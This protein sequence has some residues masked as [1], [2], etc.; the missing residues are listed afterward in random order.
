MRALRSLP[1]APLLTVALALATV[2]CREENQR[3]GASHAALGGEIA[4]RVGEFD[5]PVSLVSGVARQRGVAPSTALALLIEDALAASRALEH[6]LDQAADVR[7]ATTAAKARATL[8]RIRETARRTPPTDEEVTEISAIHWTEVDRPETF[9]VVHAVVR[10]P[11]TPDAKQEAAARGVAAAIA[12]AEVGAEDASTFEARA[13]AIPHGEA[14]VVVQPLE[15]F[16]ADGRVATPGHNGGYDPR[17]TSGAATLTRP[18]STSDVVE[19][20]FGWHVV[21]LLERRPPRIVPLDDRRTMFAEETY[22]KR[23]R[24]AVAEVEREVEVRE[25]VT[26]ANGVD[27]ILATALPSIRAHES[28]Q[29][30]PAAP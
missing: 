13:K 15:A 8:D 1:R 7:V 23:A 29:D 5:L 17:F 27:E 9:L 10:R 20:S 19:S 6:G 3:R 14:E 4:A 16:T 22:A 26:R 21:L 11:K 12:A 25:T 24:D 30:A 2:T 18:G 28:A